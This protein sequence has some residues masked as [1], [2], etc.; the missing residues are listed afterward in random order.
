MSAFPRSL[1]V[2]VAVVA[3][4]SLAY[5]GNP[6]A[7]PTSTDARAHLDAG[8]KLYDVRDFDKAID[9]YKAGA[10]IEP[11][12]IFDYNLG[13][14][15]RQLGKYEDA[16]WH[17][18]RFIKRG[19]PAGEVLDTI[20]GFI[21]QMKAERDK[22]AMTEPPT[23]AAPTITS[24]TATTTTTAGTTEPPPPRGHKTNYFALGLG[25]AG[26]VGMVAGAG[27]LW[28]AHSLR[29]DANHT[30]SQ[31]E[32]DALHDKAD[33]RS[34]AGT[35]VG[36]GGV[37]VLGTG[38]AMWLLSRDAGQSGDSVTWSVGASADTLFV[39]GSF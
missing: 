12:P 24:P 18:D 32:R 26:G 19:Q 20:N 11:T 7:K 8:N 21:A 10:L 35:I 22:K 16:I 9:E 31:Q 17:Y 30:T 39:F 28:D 2:G 15:Y 27:L 14:C 29:D 37:A 38:V 25:I 34:L 1:V 36:L 33:T 4:A 6:F 5:A 23:E 3:S 13:Q